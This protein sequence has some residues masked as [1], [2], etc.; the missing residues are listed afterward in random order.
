[1]LSMTMTITYRKGEQQLFTFLGSVVN[2]EVTNPCEEKSGTGV[3]GAA[4]LEIY[5][6]LFGIVNGKAMYHVEYPDDDS[7]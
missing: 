1:M 5:D 7:F 4:R 2:P 6:E 3:L